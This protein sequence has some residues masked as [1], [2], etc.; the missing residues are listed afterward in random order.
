[1]IHQLVLPHPDAVR[2]LKASTLI[3]TRQVEFDVYEIHDGLTVRRNTRLRRDGRF[4]EQADPLVATIRFEQITETTLIG[5]DLKTI[6]SAGWKTQRD[7]Y[8]DWLDRRHHIDPDEVV[9]A[10]R[11][12]HTEADRFLDRRLHRAY[13]TDPA[14]AVIGERVEGAVRAVDRVEQ[15]RMSREARGRDELIRQARRAELP[16]EE[17]I[18]DLSLRALKGSREAQRSLF[19]IRQTVERAERKARRDA[20]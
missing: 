11:F 16:L 9:R 8:D 3:L 18:R 19:T 2:V 15:E 7:F 17:R 1:M 5:L 10:C 13:T 12:V 14:R 4:D 20:A 6:R